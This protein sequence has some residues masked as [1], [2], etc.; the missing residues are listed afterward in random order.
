MEAGG[1]RM[2]A[3][4]GESK[5]VSESE[6]IK[7]RS[8]PSSICHSDPSTLD[9]QFKELP[10]RSSGHCAAT[11][12][13]VD[14]RIQQQQ[15]QQPVHPILGA[16]DEWQHL[17]EGGAHV[18]YRR[19]SREKNALNAQQERAGNTSNG[20]ELEE[21]SEMTRR[22]GSAKVAAIAPPIIDRA[23]DGLKG[24]ASYIALDKGHDGSSSGTAGG[25]V[26]HDSCRK[27]AHDFGV[28][29]PD[30]DLGRGQGTNWVLRVK[31]RWLD[32]ATG[33]AAM[34]VTHGIE[35]GSSEQDVTLLA[36]GA[37]A[38]GEHDVAR[39]R[40]DVSPT[41]PSSTRLSSSCTGPSPSSK[42]TTSATASKPL[43]PGTTQP[44][45][46]P[47][48]L[49]T[50]WHDSFLPL[51]V[52]YELLPARQHIRVSLAWLR[53]L[54]A[55]KRVESRAVGATEGL[56]GGSAAHGSREGRE[57][58]EKGKG[59]ESRE[60]GRDLSPTTTT[61]TSTA[62]G[63]ETA[64]CEKGDDAAGATAAAQAATKT[65]GFD[66]GG[67]GAQDAQIDVELLEDLLH[68][69]ARQTPAHF[70]DEE[71]AGDCG[72]TQSHS[73]AHQS[74]PRPDHRSKLAKEAS[75]VAG[76]VLCVEFKP[77]WGLLAGPGLRDPYGPG[78]TDT[79]SKV[80]TRHC[81]ACLHR[82]LKA[83]RHRV[84]AFGSKTGPTV[85]GGGT[86]AETSLTKLSDG[87]DESPTYCALDLYAC[88]NCESS[89][90]IETP[91][92]ASAR[93]QPSAPSQADLERGD[94]Q[95]PPSSRP[96]RVLR[97]CRALVAIWRETGG[98]AASLR[99]YLDGRPFRP[100]SVTQPEAEDVL[101]A[102]HATAIHEEAVA[103]A[104]ASWL[105]Y[106]HRGVLVLRTLRNLQAAFD[107]WD[108]ESLETWSR[109]AAIATG[110]DFDAVVR[111]LS[112]EPTTEELSCVIGCY[113][114]QAAQ[115]KQTTSALP[116]DTT[117][118]TME[119]LRSVAFGIGLAAIFKD[120]SIIVQIPLD[121]LVKIREQ[122]GTGAAALV[123][124]EHDH[125]AKLIDLDI[126]P[127]RKLAGWMRLDR[128]IR[129]HSE[130]A[131]KNAPCRE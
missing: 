120:C 18:V 65:I 73:S 36:A 60:G 103:Y 52:P 11:M 82:R 111:D 75:Q 95:S 57:G 81:R 45:Q 19:R 91:G 44:P 24:H 110:C 14:P 10:G 72:G 26:G 67:Q 27:G 9:I 84:E 5:R 49:P 39:G 114:A 42:S 101:S 64:G 3:T 22:R 16:P 108:I 70:P 80:K 92:D 41:S 47:I 61:T 51:L 117:L 88:A 34:T 126:K 116:V 74:P 62:Q 76:R 12:T 104:L 113:T 115:N 48:S 94:P 46:L 38:G 129:E 112:A 56:G 58:E 71:S 123:A 59:S 131:S 128:E 15:Q 1:E 66:V 20:N 40:T 83:A 68:P 35:D 69:P 121:E 17:A 2:E 90:P 37:S 54:E 32:L 78:S 106:S 109:R 53:G 28:A 105:S 4:G 29:P 125:Y 33:P 127:M 7:H 97:A 63:G 122:L 118:P 6:F 25:E 98:E 85:S 107:P 77:K 89:E 8:T 50:S 31:K 99:M 30:D 119:Q 43:T 86:A 96:L 124:P 79:I 102:P 23:D 100:A 21:R 130:A 87:Q 13:P 55:Y 93:C